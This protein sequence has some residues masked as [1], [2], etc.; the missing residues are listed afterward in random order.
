MVAGVNGKA[1][2]TYL[3][4]AS[5]QTA[6]DLHGHLMPGNEEEAAAFVDA[7]LERTD[8]GS[9]GSEPANGWPYS[10][11]SCPTLGGW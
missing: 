7:Y 3:G 4:H 9:P 2:T 11:R 8:T 1:I 5:V 10:S 6:F